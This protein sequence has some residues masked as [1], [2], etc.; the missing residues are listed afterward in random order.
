MSTV[1]ESVD[2]AVPVRT[3]YNQWTQFEQF[4]HFMGGVESIRQVTDDMTHWTVEIGGVRREF[5]AKI[6]E[7]H[8]DERVSWTTLD[9]PKHAGVVTFHRLDETHTRVT[10]QM[11]I[12]PSGVAETVGDKVGIIDRQVKNDVKKFKEYIES[13]GG[14]ETGAWRGD[15][16]RPTP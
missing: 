10:V 11:D 3:A 16:D 15:I 2:V 6:T 14:N 1:V 5:D 8:P 9:G 7:Q 12:E 13:R 4:P